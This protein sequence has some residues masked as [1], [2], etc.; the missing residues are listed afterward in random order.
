MDLVFLINAMTMGL[1]LVVEGHGYIIR[2]LFPQDLEQHL[3]KSQ[4]RIGGLTAGVGK[5]RQ[6]VKGTVKVGVAVDE[7]EGGSGHEDG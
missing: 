5:I 7:V 2:V 6:G 4:N 3:G 1:A